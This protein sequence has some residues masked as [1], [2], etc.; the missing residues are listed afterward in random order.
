MLNRLLRILGAG[1]VTAG[2]LLVAAPLLAS[3]PASHDVTVPNEGGDTVEVEWSGLITPGVETASD[4]SSAPTADPHTIELSVPTGVYERVNVQMVARVEPTGPTTE[5]TDVIVTLIHPDGTV[6]SGDAGFVGVPETTAATNPGAG[7]W[8]VRACAFLG[9]VPQ[10]Y[11]GTLTLTAQAVA[12]LAAAGPTC[13]APAQS[14]KFTSAYI[15]EARAGGEPMIITHPDGQLLWGSHAGTTHFYT[16]AAPSPSTG[17]FVENYEGQTYAYVSEDGESW[18]FV[19]RQ[20]PGPGDVTPV[21]GL[22]ATGFSDPEFAVD[23]AGNVYYSEIN[24]AN[25]AVYRSADGGRSYGLQNVFGFTMSDRQWMAAD[26][27]NELYMSASGFGGGPFPSDPVGTLEHF[28]AKSTDGGVTWGP[29]TVIGPLVGDLRPDQDRG[30][31]YSLHEENGTLAVARFAN[32]R[33]EAETLT[34]EVLP[35]AEGIGLSG[36]QRLIDPTLAIDG[37]G[38]LYA[39]WTDNGSGLR[40]QGIWYAFST[41]QGE[42]WS[43]PTR[44]DQ[45]A[46]ADVW[47]WIEVGAP[48][49]VAI[50]WLQGDAVI[51]GTLPGEEGGDDVQWSVAV[52]HTGTGLGCDVSDQAG[53]TVVQAS[54]EPVHTG[55]ICQHGTTCQA[56]LT[57]RR[58][59]D[60]FSV[61]VDLDGVV[62]VA[63]SDTRQGGAVALPL[64]VR[65]VGGPTL[66][67][68]PEAPGQVAP[69]QAPDEPTPSTGGGAALA[70]LGA[71][72]LLASVLRRRGS[73]RL[74][75]AATR[76]A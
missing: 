68:P 21:A 45:D 59:G 54:A 12:P 72:A 31:L 49:Q 3:D 38:N 39:V 44:V 16:P 5:A 27:E 63:V 65:Q 13:P 6:Q 14:L 8:E 32:I 37:A 10:D 17:A 41:D 26:R 2:L 19:P 71:L 7:T 18:D 42:T 24:L 75:R 11:R 69:P 73:G 70:G 30:I 28:I 48:G 22:P 36:V 40:E 9:A 33:N 35:I 53:F 66:D 67:A 55:T 43:L 56:D 60:Y 61:A 52:A 1:L 29:A 51:E 58:L 76:G 4:C 15:D 62:H 64:H 34:F 20:G 46:N 57:D 74:G 47:P 25:V 23:Q 50:T